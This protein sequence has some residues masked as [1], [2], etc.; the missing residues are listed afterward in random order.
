MSNVSTEKT[1]RMAG[2]SIL[3]ALVIVLQIVATFVK[4]GAF[5]VTLTL[6]PIVI[7]GALY[8][9]K[10]GAWL[11][12]VFGFVVMLMCITGG[13]G[14]GAILWNANPVLCGALCMLKGISAGWAAAC[15]YKA[16]SSKSDT[17]AVV[18]AAI[19]SPVVNT[20]I[21]IVGVLAFFQP[22]LLDWAG[23]AGMDVVNYILFGLAGVNFIIEMVLNIVL[24][25]V[26]E[27]I[28]NYRVKAL[29]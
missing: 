4:I 6:V 10:A 21:F 17:G 23:V 3:T 24:S 26:I 20:G 19:I 15:M 2:L 11:G 18:S 13:D 14:G 7:G 12:G 29:A 1:R 25:S 28:I 27:R 5:P 22:T 9:R 16:V 8:G